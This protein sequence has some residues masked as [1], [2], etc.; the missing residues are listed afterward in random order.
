ML[1]TV[2]PLYR[3]LAF[4]A[5]AL[6]PVG[7]PRQSDEI[8]LGLASFDRAWDIINSGHFDPDFNGVD[9]IDVRDTLRP[10]AEQASDL[11]GVRAVTREMLATLGQSHFALIEAEYL[12]GGAK[13]FAASPPGTVGFDVRL[14]DEAIWVTRVESGSPAESAGIK[15]GWRLTSIDG[16]AIDTILEGLPPNP[17]LRTTTHARAALLTKIDGP[18]GAERTYTFRSPRHDDPLERKL[19][20]VDRN[21]VPFDMPGLPTFYLTTRTERLEYRGHTIGVLH[22]S[23]W[24][25]GI[26]DD[27]DHALVGFRD[28]DGIVLDLRG[29]S[30]GNGRLARRVAAHFFDESTSLGR[31]IM[32]RGHLEYIVRPRRSH[33]GLAAS[34]YLGPLAIL[35]DETTGSCSEIFTGGMQ[36][37]ER[38]RV[39]GERSAGAGL[40]A[41]LTELPS[42]DYLLHAIGDFR[43]AKGDSLEGDGVL[44]DERLELHPTD[45]L[46]GRD[47]ALLAACAWI[48]TD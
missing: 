9:W 19:T 41:T 18:V 27:I 30:G 10:K 39:F 32:R 29:N 46:E 24:F 42:G 16:Q 17:T 13:S 45:L 8:E 6:A 35:M 3:L 44:P 14:R 4:F 25:E 21:A 2:D 28:C 48:A 33:A 1:C 47:A 38:A 31:Q 11:A 34:P 22:F 26:A 20:C 40:P 7:V 12:A 15:T 5:L 23:N 37:L 36:A 43:T